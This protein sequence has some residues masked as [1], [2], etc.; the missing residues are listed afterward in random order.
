MIR[1]AAGKFRRVDNLPNCWAWK[2][3][4]K[5]DGF[6]L[7]RRECSDHLAPLQ[8]KPITL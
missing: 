8:P 7:N 3:E 6:E 1:R 5:H 2:V 4:L